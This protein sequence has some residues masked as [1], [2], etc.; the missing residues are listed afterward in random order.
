MDANLGPFKPD[1]PAQNAHRAPPRL[2]S[3]KFRHAS[4][5]LFVGEW[6]ETGGR[7]GNVQGDSGRGQLGLV[8]LEI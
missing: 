1:H 2:G 5:T 4:L 8:G 6:M 7:S 3:D